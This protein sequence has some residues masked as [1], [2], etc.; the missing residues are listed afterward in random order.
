MWT[1]NRQ[2]PGDAVRVNDVG[3]LSGLVSHGSQFNICNDRVVATYD[4]GVARASMV[5]RLRRVF[6]GLFSAGH[7]ALRGNGD[8]LGERIKQASE[9]LRNDPELHRLVMPEARRIGW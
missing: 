4:R 3:C 9:L 5:E 7:D 8:C 2:A 6:G 1:R